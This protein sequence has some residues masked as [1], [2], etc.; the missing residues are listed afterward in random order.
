MHIK[1]ARFVLAELARAGTTQARLSH[2][3][4]IESANKLRRDALVLD[5]LADQLPPLGGTASLS[6]GLVVQVSAGA[7]K[8]EKATQRRLLLKFAAVLRDEAQRIQALR[9]ELLDPNRTRPGVT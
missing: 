6:I 7:P 5:R 2:I 1:Q 9:G 4:D 3:L 8:R